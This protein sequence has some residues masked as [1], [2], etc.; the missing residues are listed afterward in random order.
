MS[1]HE[2]IKTSMIS[3]L[4]DGDAV[5]LS[6]LRGL[7]TAFTNELVS[8]K[9]KP[10]EILGDDDIL[11]V[12]KRAGKQ[13]KDSIEQFKKG[14]RE[15]LASSEEEELKI[16]QEYLP[17]MMSI[18]EIKKVAQAKKK[19]MGIDDKTKIGIL[20]GAVMKELKGKADGGDVKK[21]IEEL[22]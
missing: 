17:Q 8:Q 21:V 12:I 6:V 9:R 16:I 10:Q 2:K 22:F 19:E 4:K 15:D 13:R 5:K 1:L 18:E 7:I 14:G 3:A 11:S 20:M